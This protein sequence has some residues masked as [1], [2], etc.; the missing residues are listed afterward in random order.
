[1]CTGHSRSD[2]TK[3]SSSPSSRVS[4]VLL[5]SSEADRRCL[6]LEREGHVPWR[7]DTANCAVAFRDVFVFHEGESLAVRVCNTN[8]CGL[9]PRYGFIIQLL[10]HL[11]TCFRPEQV[12]EVNLLCVQHL[13]R[14]ACLSR[15]ELDFVTVIVSVLGCI[16]L[17]SH[18][19]TSTFGTGRRVRASATGSFEHVAFTKARQFCGHQGRAGHQMPW[20]GSVALRGCDGPR[21][22]SARRSATARGCQEELKPTQRMGKPVVCGSH[23]PGY[24][25]G[26]RKAT[27]PFSDLRVDGPER[28]LFQG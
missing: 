13:W 21:G 20:W 17:G 18:D 22:A 27:D 26:A 10:R 15:V 12:S 3:A 24:P 2:V 7:R 19:G 1:M 6:E 9:V 28:A 11:I 25:V 23:H 4:C 8:G 5:R 14:G 16:S